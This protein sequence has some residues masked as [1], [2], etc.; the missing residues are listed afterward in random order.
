MAVSKKKPPFALKG[1]TTDKRSVII[2]ATYRQ[3]A[4]YDFISKKPWDPATA[5]IIDDEGGTTNKNALPFGLCKKFGISLPDGARPRDAWEAL[6]QHG[7]YPP[8]TDKGEDQYTEDGLKEGAEEPKKGEEAKEANSEKDSQNDSATPKFKGRAQ[9]VSY[10]DKIGLS[11]GKSL[12]KVEEK[13]FIENAEKIAELDRKFGFIKRNNERIDFSSEDLVPGCIARTGIRYTGETVRLQVND[14]Y[15]SSPQQ[16]STI[17]SFADKSG[18][19]MPYEEKQASVYPIT[20]EYG[21]IVF[22]KI[23]ADDFMPERESLF[24]EARQSNSYKEMKKAAKRSAQLPTIYAGKIVNEI[25]NIAKGTEKD[26]TTLMSSY[27]E[28]SPHEW[29]AEAFA[30]SQCGSPNAI[31]LA[32]IEYLK[33]RGY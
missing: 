24:E 21:H 15:Y 22:E 33:K 16:L 20:H 13:L 2:M 23:I 10:L 18:Q 5:E 32:T 6:K 1:L 30:N 11:C 19:N 28:T 14:L 31:G 8:W 26:I 29:L 4:S 25:K 17:Q 9:A 12:D 3:N 7:V 27:G